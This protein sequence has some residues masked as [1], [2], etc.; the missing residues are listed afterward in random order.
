VC[1]RYRDP[2]ASSVPDKIVVVTGANTGLGFQLS[3]RLARTGAHVVMACRSL[4][5]AERAR[6]RLLGDIPA[7]RTT[8]LP[9]DVAE[10]ESISE[11]RTLFARQVGYLDLLINN[12]GIFG[13]PLS[14][15]SAGHELHLATNYLGPFALTG[16]L[17]PLIRERPGARIVNVG[18]LA[19]RFGTLCPHELNPREGDYNAWRAYAR[20]KVALLTYTIELGRRLRERDSNIIALGA[21]PGM[22][23]TDIAKNSPRGNPKSAIR[24]WF[25]KT[26]ERLIPSA[27]EA[28]EPI[29]H[30]ACAAGVRGGDYYGPG[31]WLEI[32]GAPAKARLD[33]RAS[34]AELSKQLWSTSEALTGVSYLSVGAVSE[35]RSHANGV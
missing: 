22:A 32:A 24:K 19:H 25:N 28:V 2:V 8:V 34:D 10:M 26:M 21:H 4:Q 12:A 5:R 29:L 17:L 9:L 16:A 13:A 18:S 20:S 27:A 7:A 33:A 11:F 14:R 6:E 23:S 31:G 3:L 15:N 1:K 35:A 30:A